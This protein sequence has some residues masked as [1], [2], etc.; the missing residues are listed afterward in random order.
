LFSIA[1]AARGSHVT[2]VEGDRS[3]AGDLDANANPWRER[4]RVVRAPVEQAAL[5]RPERAPDVV[6]VDPPRTGISA[7]AVAGLIRWRS[8]RVV[9]VSCDPP[10][11]ARDAARLV[12]AGYKLE[13]VEALDLFPNTPHVETIAVFQ[14][15]S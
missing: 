1:L 2:A 3:A 15:A 14:R 12:E 9:Y 6:I 11:L 7:A 4:V 13:S 10:T 8:P 5:R